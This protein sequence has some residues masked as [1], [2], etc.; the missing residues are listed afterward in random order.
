MN[1]R[2]YLQH[3]EE[4][5]EYNKKRV[6]DEKFNAKN[7]LHSYKGNE[8]WCFRCQHEKLYYYQIVNVTLNEHLLHGKADAASIFVECDCVFLKGAEKYYNDYYNYIKEQKMLET[9]KM[10]DM[11]RAANNEVNTPPEKKEV[12]RKLFFTRKNNQ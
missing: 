3:I 1:S 11:Q 2:E 10:E 6:K 8:I 12:K 7:L 5:W 9:K 4:M